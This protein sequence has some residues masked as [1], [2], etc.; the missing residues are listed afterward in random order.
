MQSEVLAH[1][2]SIVQRKRSSTGF[3]LHASP[4]TFPTVFTAVMYSSILSTPFTRLIDAIAQQALEWKRVQTLHILLLRQLRL[5]HHSYH[6][7]NGCLFLVDIEN[8][9]CKTSDKNV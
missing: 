5:I 7:L 9:I 2:L 1:L 4:V 8:F 6:N 3:S